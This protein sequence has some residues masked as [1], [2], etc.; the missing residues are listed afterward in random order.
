MFKTI[1]KLNETG[2]I[3]MSSIPLCID[4][5]IN[6]VRIL[7][8]VIDNKR[9]KTM[10][11]QICIAVENVLLT[12]RIADTSHFITEIKLAETGNK[13]N[14]YVDVTEYKSVKNLVLK[15][16]LLADNKIFIS[17]AEAM[18]IV[19]LYNKSFI[20]YSSS[21]FL[22]SEMTIDPKQFTLLIKDNDSRVCKN[23]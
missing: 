3:Y 15:H 19:D 23:V 11:R 1:Q 21:Q 12:S 4:K 9:E 20:G 16:K 8:K 22:E 5:K 10:I 6:L 7:E 17:K 14:K 13:Q 2:S 18:S